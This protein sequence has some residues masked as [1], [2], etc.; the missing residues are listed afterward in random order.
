MKKLGLVAI[1]FIA[2]GLLT[3]ATASAQSS[4][5]T[6]ASA[7]ARVLA[8]ITLAKVTDLNFGDLVAGAALGTVVVDT[9]G[10]R[11]STGGVSLAVGT[12][13][14][15]SF[16]VTGEPNKTYTIAAPASV[17]INSGANNMTVNTFTSNLASPATFPAG[18]SQTL[19]LGATLN[20]GANQAT[21]SYT[22]TFNVTVAYN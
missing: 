7:S 1:G 19:N 10:A 9:A 16:T 8:K 6:S 21:G 15:A 3:T 17:V 2:L 11:T 5:T 4:A 13:S 22:N 14:Q 20:V 18:G 12:V